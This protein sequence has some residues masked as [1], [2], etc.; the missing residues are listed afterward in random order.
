MVAAFQEL[1]NRI[2]RVVERYLDGYAERLAYARL[3]DKLFRDPI[4]G[5]QRL[6]PHEVLIVDSPLFQRLR[7]I[8]QTSVAYLT[9]PSA[10]H[11]RFEHSLN[12]LHLAN[13]VLDAVHERHNV[14]TE[15]VRAEVRLSA[16]LHDIGHGIF[17]H[18]S[19]F[20]YRDFEEFTEALEDDEIRHGNAS[21]SE[22]VNYCIIT[23]QEFSNL[24][25]EPI[26]ARMR[27]DDGVRHKYA[28]VEDVSLRAIA[29]RII[30]MAPGDEPNR[31]YETDIV[32]GALD[33]DK[34]DYLNRDSYFTGVSLA[35][36]IERLLP[37]LRVAHVKNKPRNRDERR[38]VVDHRGIAVVEQLLFA[39]MIL[40]DTVYHHHK[41]RAA[42]QS[43]R[44]LLR[45]HQTT[46][47]WPT[48]S[49]TLASVV[50]F[51]DFDEYNFFGREYD[52][53]GLSGRIG[54]LRNRVLMRRALV[55][56]PR[57]VVDEDSYIQLARLSGDACN[58]DDPVARKKAIAFFDRLLTRVL[59]LCV[60]I[61]ASIDRSDV[62]IDIPDPP[63]FSRL[64]E[65]TFVQ[66]AAD[67]V[68][69]LKDLFPFQKVVNNYTRHYKYRSYVFASEKWAA[70]IAYATFRALGEFG[71]HLNDLALLLAHQQAGRARDLLLRA[72]IEPPDWK[73]N[74]YLPDEVIVSEQV[75][76]EG[77]RG[78][79]SVLT[80][81][82]EDLA[83]RVAVLQEEVSRARAVAAAA[84][85]SK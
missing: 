60:E 12:C 16:L 2:G 29:Q 80:S 24:L 5:F 61:G 47:S 57:T 67:Y 18:G 71:I 10:I 84:T 58:R 70:E 72:S 41:V 37:S 42:T 30:G 15:P 35:I 7:G 4:F 3:E 28:C 65:E 55:F 26:K 73:T 45:D 40:Y 56:A 11:T 69:Q 54:Q 78:E 63:G 23:C 8:F 51:L 39:R 49:K 25:W 34:L 17:S 14:V 6:R 66:F 36:D 13:R 43:L 64:G 68:V 46:P 77:L 75:E 27:E 48:S 1:R 44:S 31:R 20:F 79:L 82:N 19:E 21:P 9:Y 85:S 33:V 83:K 74:Y 32:N 53:S 76:L 50:D 38:L 52:D 22:L 59:D 62:A 81:E